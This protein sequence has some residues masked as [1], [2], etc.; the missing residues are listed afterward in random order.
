MALIV[1]KF[2]GSSVAS[3]D[4]IRNVARR[5]AETARAGHQVVVV[6]SAM[7][8]TTDELLGLA[9][10]VTSAPAPREM[11][12][13]LTTGEQVSVALLSLA[14]QALGLPSVGLTGGQ[15]GIRTEALHG[16]ARIAQ[17][18]TTRIQRE[19][20]DGHVVIVA[21][22][23]GVT[24]RGEIT[25]LGR[26]G[27]DTTAVALAAAVGADLCEIYTDVDGVYTTDPRVVKQAQ[28]IERISFDE[29]LELATL[30][31]AVL[32]PRAV[33]C[34]KKYGVRLM[35]RSSFTDAPGTLIG[36]QA[37]GA[38]IAVSGIAHDLGV[39]KV[40][41]I[42]VLD[43]VGNLKKVFEALAAA[44]I[45][46]NGIVN[47]V[48]HEEGRTDLSFLIGEGDVPQTLDVLNGLL[49]EFPGARLVIETNLAKVSIVGAGMA[50]V[51]GVAAQ[52]FAALADNS[53][54]IGLVATTEIT[55][56]CV[57]AAELV[58]R[59]V[60]VLHETFG[61]NGVEEAIVSGING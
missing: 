43:R 22:F 49:P 16:K 35:V 18:D 4:R 8:D 57:V 1:Q 20:Q 38:A 9:A 30:G 56:T 58:H 3:A 61:L 34:A 52:M 17:I 24:E 39:V 44:K 29:M 25:T 31:A 37:A 41:L 42:D 13:L 53:I 15:A 54:T 47:S 5:V 51:P 11:D 27:S 2:G 55:V 23:Q 46:V 6:V 59:A 12:L 36:E 40:S 19:L 60:Q 33:E 48:A 7:G 50:D 26:G 14:V 10:Q 45:I 32:H 28:K 21:G